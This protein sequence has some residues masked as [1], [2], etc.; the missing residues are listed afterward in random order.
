MSKEKRLK[1]KKRRLKLK[2]SLALTDLLLFLTCALNSLEP[3]NG[4]A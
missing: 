4:T 1:A 3:N 2:E